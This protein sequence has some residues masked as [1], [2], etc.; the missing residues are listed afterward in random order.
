MNLVAAGLPAS[1]SAEGDQGFSLRRNGKDKCN[2]SYMKPS[3]RRSNMK[4]Q[5][6]FVTLVALLFMFGSLTVIMAGELS[7]DKQGYGFDLGLVAGKDYVSGQLIVGIKEGVNVLGISQA[8]QTSGGK[9]LRNIEGAILL[10]FPS[11]QAS[12]DAVEMLTE[13]PDVTFVERNGF[14]SIPPK[15][16]LP[17]IKKRKDSSKENFNASSVSAESVSAD[18][19]AGY[20]WHHTVIRKTAGLGTLS[21]APPTVAVVDTGVDYT[22]PDLSGKVI[23]GKNCVADN[24]DPFDDNGHG[25]HVAGIIAARAANG[26]YGEGVCPKCKILAIK[27]LGYDGTGTF[28]DV[29][30]GMQN[31]RTKVT[32]PATKVINMS[33][34]GP[35][36]TLISNEVNAIKTAGM[37]L[38]AAAGNDNTTGTANAFPGADPDTALRVTATEQH[39]CRTWF[40][41]FS[42]SGNPTRYNIAAPGW[43]ISS[44]IPGAGYTTMSGTSM[45]SPVVAGAAAL[46]W[47]EL[48][49]L[50]RDELA[51]QIVDNGKRISCGFAAPT[52]RLDVRKAILGTPETAIIGRILDPFTGK[53]PSSP[54][55]PTKATLYSGETLLASDKTNTSGFYEITGI[56]AGTNRKLNGDR[57]NYVTATVRTPIT[58]K[59]ETVVGPFTDALPKSRTTGNLTITLDWKRMQPI[60]YTPGCVDACNGWEFDLIVKLPSGQYI[61]PYEFDPCNFGS[62]T[63]GDLS[64]SPYVKNPRDS[65]YSISDSEMVLEP[66]ETIVIGSLADNGTYSVIV[67]RWGFENDLF[68]P[69]WQGSGASVQKYNGATSAGKYTPPSTCDTSEFWYIGDLK[70]TGTSYTWTTVNTCSDTIP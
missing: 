36:S 60:Y 66:V 8:Y 15:P 57:A 14:M 49:S 9:V 53:A 7:K 59:S 1:G 6:V 33:L 38:V 52:R 21:T 56:T 39:D 27:V 45:A 58:I 12:K 30:C 34:A 4:R 63:T 40:S 65:Y 20:Q 23:H 50:T 24:N 70:K 11:E 67:D 16:V 28:F 5:S 55:T 42:P 41:N 26:Q 22:H 51:S 37:V 3:E 32:T 2:A 47:G 17:D 54:V 18:P 29:A 68:N 62:C 13:R 19:G 46:V 61:T 35:K 69:S 25:T 43:E 48:P 31:A 10:E 64:T 44:T